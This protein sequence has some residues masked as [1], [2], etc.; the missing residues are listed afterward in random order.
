MRR[1]LAA[2]AAMLMAFVGLSLTTASAAT[3]N[4]AAAPGAFLLEDSA[5]APGTDNG[6]PVIDATASSPGT[7]GNFSE[8]SLTNIPAACDGRTVDV[9]AHGEGG[10]VVATGSGTAEANSAAISVGDY[11]GSAV[12]AVVVR[13]SGWLFPTNWTAPPPPAAASCVGATSAPV[14]TGGDCAITHTGGTFWGNTGSRQGHIS[15]SVTTPAQNAIVTLDLSQAPYAGWTVGGVST[16][17]DWIA[18][19]GYSCS[20]LPLVRLYANPGNAGKGTTVYL[21]LRESPAPTGG[22]AICPGP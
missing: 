18:V 9:Y 4:L 14:G 12:T 6:N 15:F 8:I 2:G 21:N 13:I 3:L 22:G 1:I 10:A 11:T 7:A 5:C 19:P 16:N 17:G 20:E